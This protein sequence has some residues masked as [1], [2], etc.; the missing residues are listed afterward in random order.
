[1]TRRSLNILRTTLLAVVLTVLLLAGYTQT[2]VFRANLRSAAYELLQS[3]LNASVY[4][5]EIE[6]NLFT[7]LTI[8]TVMIY[9]DNAPFVEAGRVGVRYD[10]LDLLRDRVT[11]DSV[12]VDNPV[13]HLIRWK[14]GS[15]NTGHLAPPDT[16]TDTV[17][18]PWTIAAARVRLR[19][20][21][22]RLIDSTGGYGTSV[23][24]DGVRVLNYSN[25]RLTGIELAGSA[26]IAPGRIEAVIDSLSFDAPAERFSLERLSA[27]VLLAGDT[28]RV[29]GLSIRTGRS[30]L[31]LSA[32]LTGVDVLHAGSLASFE[33][34]QTALVLRPSSVSSADLQTF[35]PALYFLRGTVELEGDVAGTFAQMN[36]RSLTARFGASE[37]RLSGTVSNIHEPD[38]LRL[39]VVSKQSVIDPPD[40]PALLPYYQIPLFAKLGTLS[41]DFQYVGKPLDFMVVSTVRSAAGT[42]T[43]DG[44]MLITEQHLHYKGLLAGTDVDLEKV[45]ENRDLAS[46]INTRAYIEGE[47]TSIADLN[48]EARVEIDS[49]RIR[50]ID[51]SSAGLALRAQDRKIDADLSLRSPDGTAGASVSMDFRA[52]EPSYALTARVRGLDLAPILRDDYYS[53]RLSFDLHRTAA[54][55]DPLDAVSATDITLLPSTFRD[56]SLD[57]ASLSFAVALD[58]AGMRRLSLRSPVGDAELSGRFTF[59]GFLDVLQQ[60]VGHIVRLYAY[61]RQ[62]VDSGFSR[63]ADTVSRPVPAPAEERNDITYAIDVR[64]LRPISVFFDLPMM[65]VQGKMKGK[66]E[67]SRHDAAFSGD[68]QIVRGSL[69]TDSTL[70]Q[71]R[72]SSL[73]FRLA[74]VPHVHASSPLPVA[75]ELALNGSEVAVNATVLRAPKATVSYDGSR[76]S[77]SFFSDIDTTISAAAEGDITVDTTKEE[78][79]MSRLFVRYQG[80]D[81]ENARAFRATLSREG[82][83]VD[84]AVLFHRGQTM[85]LD[86]SYGFSGTLNAFLSVTG[87]PLGDL[88]YFTTQ[89][90]ARSAFQELGGVVD[91]SAVLSGS[92]DDPKFVV[93]V[94]GSGLS[95]RN[96]PIGSLAGSVGY[97][98]R[99]ATIAVEMKDERDST[100][101]PDLALSGIV[102]ID[103]RFRPLEERTSLPGLNVRLTAGRLLMSALDPFIPELRD[104]GGSLAG[105]L[106]VT[107][108]L[109]EPAFDGAMRLDS[110]S[111]L[112]EMTGISYLASG[113]A[114]FGGRTVSFRDF[115]VMNRPDEFAPSGMSVGGHILLKGFAPAE[116]HLSTRGE[117]QV[118]QERSRSAG[119]SFFGTLVASTGDDSLRFT[120]TYERSRVTGVVLV[121]QAALTFPPT[122]QASAYSSSVYNIVEFVDDTTRP[123]IDTTA[124]ETLLETAQRLFTP[125]ERTGPSFL[126]GF[127]Y[128]L[129]IQTSGAVR[130]NM[131]FNANAGAYEEL[132]AELNGKLTLSKDEAGNQLK[133]TINVGSE[134]KYT[135]YKT[136]NASG[137]LTFTGDAQNP[138]LNILAAYEGL[139]CTSVD[140]V[141]RNCTDEE[142]VVVTL[143]IGGTRA[144]PQVKLGLKTIDKTGKE[145][146]RTGDVE[147]DAISFL[148]TSSAGTPGKFRD[149]LTAQDRNLISEQ[150]T[151][152]IGGTYINSLLSSYMMEFVTR[153]N[154]PFVKRLEVSDVYGDPNI[155]LRLEVFDAVIN[156]G[157]KVFSNINNTNFSV[158]RPVLGRSSPNFMVEVEKKTEN[159]NYS[160]GSRTILSARIYYRFLF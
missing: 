100:A 33:K 106:A 59:P 94:R 85:V 31:D 113:T 136:F 24:I 63:S 152:A 38:E 54:S 47:G 51:V 146:E 42:V 73:S 34:A 101:V 35:L 141:S 88:S 92:L 110:G 147:N 157:G 153:N 89:P 60:G 16:T 114:L 6:G 109:K 36:V 131:I 79:T 27:R 15:W 108:S 129:T 126:D 104:I 64:N 148:L 56:H 23:T 57:S 95:Y 111:F 103:L 72:Q 82:L 99:E 46:R 155:N 86:G 143:K 10:L 91:A 138:Q 90:D 115:T 18:S 156:A 140:P 70:V 1:M 50:G 83:D 41:L 107:G 19:N 17:P 145:I 102:P 62:V 39:N 77:F 158:Q 118:L 96:T 68:L 122:Q 28:A 5:G 26:A 117:L 53:S 125:P 76:G 133:G 40:V 67:G 52:G 44:E 49:S 25:L 120:G 116:Y 20:A 2:A 124:I 21:T 48:A 150:L 137:S 87:F 11:V 43:V 81:V 121:R 45:F 30:R 32:A 142:R 3:S 93:D 71:V 13:V 149:E 7:G 75:V 97:D 9:V 144:V 37:L 127:G 84:S 151:S 154:I 160:L 139:H 98:D 66:L 78:L 14:D 119:S 55:F 8:D 22:F 132:Y 128:E 58:S 29:N 112:F 135:F 74:D 159:Y 4:I 130:V 134:S 12:T 61:Q 123:V 105:E 80:F 65:D 69:A